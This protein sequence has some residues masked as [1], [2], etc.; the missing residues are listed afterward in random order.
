MGELCPDF[1][2]MALKKTAR[3]NKDALRR[4][5]TMYLSLNCLLPHS[6]RPDRQPDEHNALD[7]YTHIE[8]SCQLIRESAS[9]IS[10]LSIIPHL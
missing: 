8:I 9:Y 7:Y 6:K 4:I 1:V 10:V 2:K 5:N 3:N